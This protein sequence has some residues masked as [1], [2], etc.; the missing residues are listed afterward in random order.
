MR[1]EMDGIKVRGA[2]PPKPV[3]KWS[4]CGLPAPWC[5]LI[6]SLARNVLA[7]DIS[8]YRSHQGTRLHGTYLDPV[9]SHPCHHVR[10]RHHRRCEDRIWQDD[11][12]HYAHV[13][14]HQG[15]APDSVNGGTDSDD[16]D[17]YTR[18]GDA[19]PQGVQAIPQGAW[20]EGASS[21]LCSSSF[22]LR[23]AVCRLRAL[24]EERHSRTTLLR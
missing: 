23:Y 7:H 1:L 3:A 11:G 22:E 18:A 20:T 6:P 10:P 17:P 5:V 24:M 2:D 8:Q 21:V 13:S 14:P 19:D 15:P 9:A 4:Y 12:V 16:H